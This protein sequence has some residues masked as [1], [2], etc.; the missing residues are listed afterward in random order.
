MRVGLGFDAHAFAAG[1][2][3][4]IGGVRVPHDR[5]LHGHSDADV[6]SH[7]IGDAVL[8]AAG[9]GDLGSMF[10]ASDRW[11][12]AS[13]LT[14]L[15]AIASAVRQADQRVVNVDATVIAQ[16][17]RMA[18]HTGDMA[19]KVAAA[20]GIESGCVSVKATSTDGLGFTGRGDG[21]AAMA[22]A[23]VEPLV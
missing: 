21:I 20:L 22:V 14:I 10:P 19:K 23:L 18:P 13:S 3:L 11:K 2:D 9:L 5:G 17:P 15:E 6:L 16:S 8:G 1:R 4:I 12:N 7:S